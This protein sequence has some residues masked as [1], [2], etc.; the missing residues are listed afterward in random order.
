MEGF[1][2]EV[3]TMWKVLV[4]EGGRC[5]APKAGKK[6]ENGGLKSQ[7]EKTQQKLFQDIFR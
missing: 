6:G 7:V 5:I 3:L 4:V 1:T 2:K